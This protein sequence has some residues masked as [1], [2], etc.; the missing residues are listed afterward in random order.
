M[1]DEGS[2]HF[3][4]RGIAVGYQAIARRTLEDLLASPDRRWPFH[5]GVLSALRVLRGDPEQVQAW[6]D[7]G[8]SAPRERLRAALERILPALVWESHGRLHSCR[9][10]GNAADVA[11]SVLEI[12]WEMTLALCLL[13]GRWVTHDYY[14]GLEDAFEFPLLPDGYRD[15]VPRLYRVREIEEAVALADRLV[16][17]F[18]RLLASEGVALREYGSVGEFGPPRRGR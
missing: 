15:L 17:G 10:R 3:L 5:M 13:S 18:R 9:E 8:R 11:P 7:L 2:D 6:L 14:E 1:S 12:L 4:V 16:E